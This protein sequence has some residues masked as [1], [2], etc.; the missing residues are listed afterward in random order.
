MVLF[1]GPPADFPSQFGIYSQPD[2]FFPLPVF[3]GPAHFFIPFPRVASPAY[4]VRSMS[5]NT[6][7]KD[8]HPYIFYVREPEM[9]GRSDIAKEVRSV[10][11][12][13]RSSDR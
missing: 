9:L 4:D 12:R 8:S 11:R 2:L 7:R 6:S 13:D 10:H 3:S 5:R 1:A